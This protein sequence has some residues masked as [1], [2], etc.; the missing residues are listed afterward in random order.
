MSYPVFLSSLT[1]RLQEEL[2]KDIRKEIYW[3][4]GRGTLVYVDD[5]INE[6]PPSADAHMLVA[7]E[8]LD[9][10]SEA[11]VFL[12]VLAGQSHGSKLIDAGTASQVSFFEIELFAAA[13]LRKEI[14][15][16]R[17]RDFRPEPALDQLLKML[18]FAFPRW[19]SVPELD[20]QALVD[21]A[22]RIAEE[23]AGPYRRSL[24][25]IL[26]APAK[27]IA[28]ALHIGRSKDRDQMRFLGDATATTPNPPDHP[29]VD[30]LLEASGTEENHQR[31]LARVWLA[32]R[33]LNTQPI[34][35][36]SDTTQLA[37]LEE[38][39]GA[40]QAAGGWYGL[41]ADM[42]MGCLAALNS[43]H[44]IRARR[45]DLDALPPE[46]PVYPAAELASAK[47]NIAKHLFYPWHRR[48]RLLD[49]LQD[50]NLAIAAAP[51]VAYGSL[52]VRS[53]IRRRV[54]HPAD[55]IS[56]LERAL[57]IARTLRARPE[58]I[59]ATSVEL[60]YTSIFGLRLRKA[61]RHSEE[62]IDLLRSSGTKTQLARM[63]RK[64]AVVY[65][66][67]GE[68]AKAAA[69]REEARVLAKKTRAFDQLR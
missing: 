12:C 31:R 66:V 65:A 42:T 46:T 67:N 50:V 16:L 9:R 17:H 10:I 64:S 22:V 38:V 30:R 15:V 48:A 55:A 37:K 23:S 43:V 24:R 13:L 4:A 32:L 47:Y 52:T 41:H 34:S 63:L 6:R 20:T 56:D 60:G 8:L 44:A 21:E 19:S 2:G 59:G 69:A 68:R 25:E 57:A 7:D 27:L 54:G 36:Q 11:K 62:G 14:V 1:F 40:W 61:L 33:E 26:I 18:D 29:F 49:A 28:E 51:N 35:S 45:A 5:T 58:V 3:R 39:F 53:N